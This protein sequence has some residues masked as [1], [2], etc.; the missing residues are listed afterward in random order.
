M[1]RERVPMLNLGSGKC[2][3]LEA[4][5]VFSGGQWKDK[6]EQGKKVLV[7]VFKINVVM[8]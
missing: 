2:I 8:I 3:S 1:N 6:K 5:N 7:I 4:F